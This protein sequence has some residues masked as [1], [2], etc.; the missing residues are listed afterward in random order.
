MSEDISTEGDVLI[1][2]K[3][4]TSGEKSH[5]ITAAETMTV[6]D[7]KTK[8]SG[9]D[10]E[11]VSV[12]R[13]RLIYSG[14]VMK[15]TEMLSTY[16]IKNGNTVHMV[17]SAASNTIQ[18]P[19]NS[20]SSTSSSAPAGVPLNM[21]AGTANNP[22][23]GLTG[24]RYA[25]H[26]QLPSA[27]IFGADGGMGAPPS[28]D[29]VASLLE[30]PNFL[31]TM[32][33]ALNNPALV[34]MLLNSIPGLRDNPEARAMFQSPEFRRMM[35]NPDTIRQA[36]AM[37]RLVGGGVGGSNAFPAPG[38]TDNTPESATNSQTPNNQF[39]Q[40]NALAALFGGQITPGQ[41]AHIPSVPNAD[42][43]TIPSNVVD[44]N[45]Q[46]PFLS[47]FTNAQNPLQIP[48]ITPAMAQQALAMMQAGGLNDILGRIPGSG[49][50]A[51]LGT[52]LASEVATNPPPPPDTRPPEEI[53]SEQLRQLNDMGFFDF[54]RNIAALRR[55]GGSV[56]GAI[57][58]LL[59]G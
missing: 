36:A 52:G 19:A 47:L 11:K 59:S 22:L 6:L 15:D 49:S 9:D 40:H 14:R 30:D 46:N 48:Q 7:L 41:T 50:V 55:S 32:N 18:R 54:D 58:Q 35:T 27:D 53:Y 29:Q 45:L 51:G 44:T 34:D 57:E 12:D 4:K 37:R 43:Q 25:G 38:L 16:K 13:M 2:F 39:A 31:Q 21:A 56:Q 23:A 5:T 42:G 8:L 10:Y 24:A 33:E 26:V 20:G 28:E 3:V 1:T 17:K